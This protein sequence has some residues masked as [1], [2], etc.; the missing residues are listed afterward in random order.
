METNIIQTSQDKDKKPLAAMKTF[1]ESGNLKTS[2]EIH[3]FVLNHCRMLK[4]F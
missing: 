2:R 1:L 3:F 4:N